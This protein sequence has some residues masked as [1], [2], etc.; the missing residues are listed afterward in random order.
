MFWLLPF[1][2]SENYS[3]ASMVTDV[4]RILCDQKEC[5][6]E[7]LYNSTVTETLLQPIH[8]LMKGTAVGVTKEESPS[9]MASIGQYSVD[10][11][12]GHGWDAFLQ[13]F[14]TWF[15]FFLLYGSLFF[16]SLFMQLLDVLVMT[17][18]RNAHTHTTS[19]FCF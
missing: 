3:P 4:L 8:N 11:Y 10:L 7:C 16:K 14:L 9:S 5:A 13:I 19:Y 12:F 15:F 1:C 18:G 6:I 2:F 17:G